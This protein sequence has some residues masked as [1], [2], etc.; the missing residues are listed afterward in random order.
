[1]HPLTPREKQQKWHSGSKHSV[2]ETKSK[3]QNGDSHQQI[4]L[5]GSCVTK[6][7]E[8]GTQCT[9]RKHI[10]TRRPHKILQMCQ[11]KYDIVNFFS[12][13]WPSV[14][15]MWGCHHTHLH[16]SVV[17]MTYFMRGISGALLTSCATSWFG[18]AAHSF[19]CEKWLLWRENNAWQSKFF[20]AWIWQ[21]SRS[22]QGWSMSTTNGLICCLQ[23]TSGSTISQ[24]AKSTSV[25]ERVLVAWPSSLLLCWTNWLGFWDVTHVQ[26]WQ[27][28]PKS[29]KWV[30]AWCTGLSKSSCIGRRDPPI[31]CLTTSPMCSATAGSFAV[32]LFGISKL[33]TVISCIPSS[34]W[35]KVGFLLWPSITSS[36][37]WMG[38]TWCWMPTH[39]QAG[40]S[41]CEDYDVHV[42]GLRWCDHERVHP[43]RPRNH[44]SSPSASL[45]QAVWEAM[46]TSS[47]MLGPSKLAFAAG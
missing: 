28:L 38:G 13:S 33:P 46:P 18:R 4:K 42:L 32:T 2:F 26:V 21:P 12:I 10:S 45:V 36:E 19:W 23:C 7:G 5:P 20:M 39:P 41:H 14:A 8:A 1:M 27:P 44:C 40:E 29:C 22:T 25:T 31:G 43:S 6:I 24:P 9:G 3:K 11:K 15:L 37:Q 30:L 17:T 16:D 35:M 47:C 34:P